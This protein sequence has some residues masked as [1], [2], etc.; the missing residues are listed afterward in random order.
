MPSK[1]KGTAVD[2]SRRAVN[3]AAYRKKYDSLS[4]PKRAAEGL[5][6]QARR[7][8]RDRDGHDSERMSVVSWRTG[9]LVTDT[10]SQ[11]AVKGRCGLTAEQARKA[12][13]TDGGVVLLHNHPNST[14]PSWADIKAVAENVW[15]RKSVIACHD[16]TV[17][18]L[19][20]DSPEVVGI[21]NGFLERA[22]KRMP[23]V[24]SAGIVEDEALRDLIK[25]NEE[26]KW[27]RIRRVR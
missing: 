7:I 12:A 22:K 23:G 27:F 3:G 24:S 13:A 8:L 19:T 14:E 6:G 2:V 1:A 16:G 11:R 25:A 26:A 17:W 10:F 21:F 15:V 9:A 5:Y 18:E 20:C 4:V